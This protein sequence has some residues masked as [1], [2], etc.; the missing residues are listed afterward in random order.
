MWELQDIFVN[1][2]TN[3]I[4]LQY[5]LKLLHDAHAAH[6]GDAH[7]SE[8]IRDIDVAYCNTIPAIQKFI[9]HTHFGD[10]DPEA[11]RDHY[12]RMSLLL[13]SEDPV[14]LTFAVMGAIR[15]VKKASC[16]PMH[17]NNSWIVWKPCRPARKALPVP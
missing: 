16:L 4:T 7:V 12:D 14:L 13:S 2:G 3:A 15:E 8:S 6:D 11:L 9:D 17:A 5:L 1:L 10:A